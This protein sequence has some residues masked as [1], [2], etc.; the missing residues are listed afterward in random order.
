MILTT[1]LACLSSSGH[2]SSHHASSSADSFAVGIYQVFWFCIEFVPACARCEEF[3]HT[4]QLGGCG[5]KCKTDESTAHEEHNSKEWSMTITG[6]VYYQ[7]SGRWNRG[8][9]PQNHL[10]HP[11]VT[12]AHQSDSALFALGLNLA[13]S[14]SLAARRKVANHNPWTPRG[15]Q[16]SSKDILSGGFPFLSNT[17][18]H[19]HTPASRS[20]QVRL[21]MT[22]RTLARFSNNLLRISLYKCMACVWNVLLT[23][24]LFLQMNTLHCLR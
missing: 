13:K 6:W 9:T 19:L 12:V 16:T 23:L 18:T 4:N 14:T 7:H 22:I 5:V 3:E 8:K 21:H 10:G 1:V 11:M 24:W 20:L 17:L 2:D 15:K